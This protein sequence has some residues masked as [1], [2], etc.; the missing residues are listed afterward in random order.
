M[1]FAFLMP[2]AGPLAINPA[3][4]S[5]LYLFLE[6][7]KATAGQAREFRWWPYRAGA[8]ACVALDIFGTRNDVC[9]T[10]IPGMR[11]AATIILSGRD[12]SLR[13]V[14]RRF[15]VVLPSSSSL[16]SWLAGREA[17]G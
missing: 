11:W 16:C 1:T 7:L 3:L 17:P 4:Q 12:A 6:G 14:T 13:N 2:P 5:S 15:V 8:S 10:I 9:I